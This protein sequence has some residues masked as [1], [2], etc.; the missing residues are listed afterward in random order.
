MTVQSEYIPG[1]KTNE[2]EKVLQI[3]VPL[4]RRRPELI[5][6]LRILTVL[7]VPTRGS[8]IKRLERLENRVVSSNPLATDPNHPNETPPNHGPTTTTHGSKSMAQPQLRPRT[9]FS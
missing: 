9:L 8:V 7:R 5:I 2:Y 3:C 6:S 4:E 1:V